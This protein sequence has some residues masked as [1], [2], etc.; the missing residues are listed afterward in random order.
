MGEL[1]TK[2]RYKAIELMQQPNAPAMY[3]AAVG[4]TD[5]LEWCDIP[6]TKETYMAGYQR[7]LDEGRVESIAEYLTQ[8]IKN[9]LPGAIVVATDKEY[10]TIVSENGQVYVE[11]QDDG[12]DIK[13]KIEELFGTFSTRL[14]AEELRSAQIDVSMPGEEDEIEEDESEYPVSYIAKLAQE[15]KDALQDWGNLSQERRQA[16]EDYINGVSKPGLIIDGQH[17]ALG[18][19]NVSDF[20]VILPV[21]F[22]HGL[23]HEEQVFQF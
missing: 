14:S 1:V 11:V 9:L 13:T 22:L 17:R 15:L 16:I 20:D 18:A 12:R 2:R 23:P 5:L 21:I 19:K 10:V 7:P 4:A 8:S 3:M 6:R